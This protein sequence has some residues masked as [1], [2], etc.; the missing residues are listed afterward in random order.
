VTRHAMWRE[1]NINKREDRDPPVLAPPGTVAV[2]CVLEST[3]RVVAC[4]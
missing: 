1:D 2:T 3:V 4:T